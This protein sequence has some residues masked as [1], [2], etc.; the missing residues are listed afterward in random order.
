MGK[1]ECIKTEHACIKSATKLMEQ[2]DV[3]EKGSAG[4]GDVKIT[5]MHPFG[6]GK[7]GICIAANTEEGNVLIY[8]TE[9][10]ESTVGRFDT[11]LCGRSA[12]AAL[13][14]DGRIC[15]YAVMGDKVFFAEETA[16]RSGSFAK[17]KEISVIRPP[18]G[19]FIE[20]LIMHPL[21][22]DK[23]DPFVLAAVIKCGNNYRLDLIYRK[24]EQGR[25]FLLPLT[26]E[27]F[28]L[29]GNSR[30]E[31]K[32]HILG[33]NYAVYDLE[34]EI[35]EESCPV[36]WGQ[37]EHGGV[38]L[39]YVNGTSFVL[40]RAGNSM[41]ISALSKDPKRGK[42]VP[43]ELF[44]SEKIHC[45]NAWDENGEMNFA[46]HSDMICHGTAVYG[47]GIWTASALVPIAE[48]AGV[49]R[50]MSYNKAMQL[51]YITDT[52]RQLHRLEDMG[53][54]DWNETDYES[55][56][57]DTVTPK[58]CYSTEITVTDP[59]H[60]AVPMKGVS[61]T[62]RAEK[63]AYVETSEGTSVIDEN[64][65]V[66]LTTDSRGKIFF[67]QYCSSLD[68]PNI[69]VSFTNGEPSEN[70]LGESNELTV[71]QFGHVYEE[72]KNIDADKILNAQQLDPKSGVPVPLI[73]DQYRT[74]ENAEKLSKG[75]K[76]LA[77][78]YSAVQW[79]SMLMRAKNDITK[80]PFAY[81]K[82]FS[83][84]RM[85]FTDSGSIVYEEL[86]KSRAAEMVAGF[87]K[88]N[89]KK[90]PQW[91]GKIGDFFRSVAKSI[92]KV[93]EIVIDGINA[94]VR[95]V[96]NGVEMVFETVLSAVQDVLKF[97]EIIFK[98]LMVGFKEL[99]RWLASLFGWNYV[100]YTK[101][102]VA[103][104]A[105]I[106]LDYLP[107][108]AAETGQFLCDRIDIA[109]QSVDGWIDE[110]IK[111]VAPEKGLMSY[112]E[113]AL[114]PEDDRYSYELSNDPLQAKLGRA[115]SSG[116]MSAA[117]AEIEVQATD[118]IRLFYDKLKS[119]EERVSVGDEFKEA[120]GFFSEAFKDTEN[121]FSFMTAGIL[122][123]VKGLVHIVLS[124]CKEIVSDAFELMGELI[125]E[126]KK[127]ITAEIK[128]PVISEIY[129]WLT[130]GEMTLLDMVSLIIALPATLIG[131]IAFGKAPF[132]SEAEADAFLD[133]VRRFLSREQ[134]SR[135]Q[136]AGIANASDN[137]NNLSAWAR[138]L[139]R[140][141]MTASAFGCGVI[142]TM[143][144]FEAG[145]LGQA[146]ASESDPVTDSVSITA[147]VFEFSW[148]AF[149]L[150]WFYGA[151]SAA[152]DEYIYNYTAWGLFGLG[153]AIDLAFYFICK[154]HTHM[155][156]VGRIV[157]SVY[158]V[159]HFT[160]ALTG[161]CKSY[162]SAGSFIAELSA[163]V[164]EMSKFLLDM[165]VDAALA[166]W[167][168]D[169]V[170]VA[171]ILTGNLITFNDDLDSESVPCAGALGLSC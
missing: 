120:T 169:V 104:M 131:R 22:E 73:S 5:D 97:V 142:N 16:P 102:A 99:F 152:S 76:K 3:C 59:V 109:G 45:F 24:G 140:L 31:L 38:Q 58:S 17:S 32:L 125:G 1:I 141:I 162:L 25:L 53:G 83:S 111:K 60:T 74:R 39:E 103:G 145:T 72:M 137:E 49:L 135:R 52:D 44:E 163:S 139:V 8:R 61:V 30:R 160:C 150:P 167:V 57:P 110:I 28:T 70:L 20:R 134:T 37:S 46:V 164:T 48:N 149:S 165:G 69:Y 65:T 10:A 64:E 12:A 138:P 90:L 126:L 105:E 161:I 34:S 91:L 89:E 7:A 123:S 155:N 56:L 108:K 170:G 6:N 78:N 87:K 42:I 133:E 80:T 153:C 124:G 112:A 147:L 67:R 11:G 157:T 106:M 129:S 148:F 116:N 55:A 35:P 13:D 77:D 26:S 19:G 51:F 63:R 168:I 21:P 68:V 94:A 29:S 128:I 33:D 54:G 101:K 66:T 36:E 85:E 84:W 143:L 107:R 50:T 132:A 18:E 88:A 118:S 95:F 9:G 43:T 121:F 40:H 81:Q 136:A 117:F 62:L 15:A 41:K 92:V 79:S 115:F 158:G 122:S 47:G 119:F 154:K 166:A 127:I 14:S 156:K 82:T 86:T 4:T 71:S 171:F 100:L 146:E 98:P 93:C 144:D 27:C 159:A 75:I 2:L 113:E 151:A 23:E 130:D 114:P 96:L